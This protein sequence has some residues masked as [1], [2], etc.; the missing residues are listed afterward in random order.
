MGRKSH[1]TDRALL[2]A[3][4]ELIAQGNYD[5]TVRAICTLANVN[6]GMFVY[7]F[8]FKEEYMKILFRKIYENYLEYLQDYPDKDA[9]ALTQLQHIFYR[10][11]KYFVN[12]FNI[13][14]FITDALLRHK[15]AAYFT[16]YRVQ[17]FIFVRTLIEQAQQD[18]EICSDLNSYEIYMTLQSILLQPII[19]KNTILQKHLDNPQMQKLSQLDVTSDESLQKRLRIAFKGLRP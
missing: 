17:H 7:Y 18:G 13:A 8:S 6:Q 4:R 12:H 19:V 16:N 10:M 5:P 9:S 3:G 2:Q 14:Y 1:N 15:A 11:A